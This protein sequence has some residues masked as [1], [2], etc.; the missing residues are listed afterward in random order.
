MNGSRLGKAAG[1]GAAGGSDTSGTGTVGLR[2]T[3]W[4]QQGNRNRST[5]ADL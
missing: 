1:A 5:G 3:D 2:P 4:S